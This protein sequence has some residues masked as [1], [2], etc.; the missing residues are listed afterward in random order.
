MAKRGLRFHMRAAAAFLGAV[1]ISGC[2]T[3]TQTP[4]VADRGRSNP[5]NGHDGDFIRCHAAEHHVLE[6]YVTLRSRWTTQAIG[7]ATN[8]L[9][10]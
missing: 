10:L 8:A 2:V 6:F 4:L 3:N 9:T 7:Y 5:K 1:V